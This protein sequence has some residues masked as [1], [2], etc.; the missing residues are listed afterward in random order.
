MNTIEALDAL[1][2]LAQATRLAVFRLLVKAGNDGMPAGAIATA[3]EARQNTLST[4]LGI[5]THAGLIVSERRGRSIHYR[6]NYTRM[7]NFLMFLMEDCCQNSA[8]VCAP[9]IAALTVS[10]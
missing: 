1:A 2:A 3:V 4:H 6:A 9:V 5:L 7:Q 10:D 8:T